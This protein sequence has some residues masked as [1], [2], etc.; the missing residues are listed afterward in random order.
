MT[1]EERLKLYEKV[2]QE[3]LDRAKKE[4]NAKA[5]AYFRKEFL[6]QIFGRWF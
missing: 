5:R 2:H 3:S 4:F 1:Q 6:R